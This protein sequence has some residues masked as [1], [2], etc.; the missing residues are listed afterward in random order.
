MNNDT[1]YV[2]IDF[3]INSPGVT[4]FNNNTYNFISF[5]RILESETEKLKKLKKYQ[6]HN[7]IS[8]FVD[9]KY[10]I[11]STPN[12]DYIKDQQN[13]LKESNMLADLIV[14]TIKE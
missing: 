14:N 7:L 3:S 2:G 13:K 5:T 11:R 9:I 4:I 10:Y 6:I 1:V 8:N 12:N